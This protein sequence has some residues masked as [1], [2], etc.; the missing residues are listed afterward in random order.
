MD[1]AQKVRVVGGDGLKIGGRGRG[2]AQQEVGKGRQDNLMERME[3]IEN[4][5]R[6][7]GIAILI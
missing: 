4:A 1:G 7:I 3:G 6:S 5:V 2:H